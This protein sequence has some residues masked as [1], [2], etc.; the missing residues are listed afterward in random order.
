MSQEA[1]NPFMFPGMGGA[2][3][4]APQHPLTSSMEMMRQ[5]MG[6]L[7]YGTSGPAP[8]G[9]YPMS[10]Q[11]LE[12][13]ISEL[14]VVE[15]WLKLNL[16][17]LSSTIQGL[18][19][20]LAT[21]KTLQSFAALGQVASGDT[22]STPSPL[23]VVLGLKPKPKQPTPSAASSPGSAEANPDAPAIEPSPDMAAAQGWWKM[24]EDQFVQL[25]SAT[26]QAAK[27]G[28]QAMAQAKP[29]SNETGA[30]G[31]TTK[32]ST[33]TTPKARRTAKSAQK[34]VPQAKKPL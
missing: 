19:V 7:N 5:A 24:L 33:R 1:N 4:N 6:G 15:N 21:V 31:G 28:E 18:E 32:T 20:Q 14:K 17:M 12:R 2:F 22:A 11:D 26:T 27:C 16:S 30:S 10:P 34:N 8:G 23:E 13:R 3:M 29:A 25:A 9:L